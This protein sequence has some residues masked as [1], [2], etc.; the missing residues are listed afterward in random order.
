MGIKRVDVGGGI[1]TFYKEV[2]LNEMRVIKTDKN[3][4]RYF[5]ELIT[6]QPPL[7]YIHTCIK[8]GF[9]AY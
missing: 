8:R 2:N 6:P 7:T 5:Q 9:I 3:K 4:D 1:T